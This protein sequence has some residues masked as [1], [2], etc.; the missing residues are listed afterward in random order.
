MQIYLQNV[1]SHA[2]GKCKE[3]NS[4]A[5]ALRVQIADTLQKKEEVPKYFFVAGETRFEHATN[6]F[7][8]R[9]STVEPLP[10]S[11]IKR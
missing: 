9:C 3:Y 4:D 1:V 8:D 2:T 10:Y 7:G 6:G 11:F 5:R